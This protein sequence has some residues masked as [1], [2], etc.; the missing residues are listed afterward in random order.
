MRKNRL[1]P[2]GGNLDAAGLRA[3]LVRCVGPTARPISIRCEESLRAP[4]A[5]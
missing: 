2:I 5:R 3:E 1:V 4:E